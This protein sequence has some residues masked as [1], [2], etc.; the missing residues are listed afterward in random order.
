[1]FDGKPVPAGKIYFI[2]DGSKGNTGA[3][4]YADIKDGKYDTA[5]S[6]GHGTV[7]GPMTIA[8]EGTDPAAPPDK[9]KKGEEAS[10]EA[11]MKSLFPRYEVN[12]D[13]PKSNIS[14]KNFEVPKEASKGPTQ[15]GP[16]IIIT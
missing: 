8:I 5:D 15:K 1:M 3:T 4:G 16:K 6:G 11:T 13:L 9:P 7:G 14:D 10:P 12:E 2:P